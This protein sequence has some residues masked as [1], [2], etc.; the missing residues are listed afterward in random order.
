MVSEDGLGEVEHLVLLAV[1]H[2]GSVPSTLAARLG[3]PAVEVDAAVRRLIDGEL[4]ET[5]TDT[6]VLTPQGHV[7]VTG[8]RRSGSHGAVSSVDVVEVARSLR[9]AWSA[10]AEHR[11]AS[12]ERARDTM[13]AS[14]DDRDTVLDLLSQGYA[15]GRLSANEFDDRTGRALAARTYGALDDALDGLGAMER[16][17]ANHPGRKVVFWVVAVPCA[18]FVLM[19]ALLFAFGSDVG[20]HVGGLLFLAVLLPLLFMIRRWAWPRS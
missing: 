8:L 1:G 10:Q 16:P 11:A 3:R 6:V 20:D 5:T 4:L 2:Q 17:R 12:L 7:I 19:G 18:P 13:L 9:A 15:E 14:D